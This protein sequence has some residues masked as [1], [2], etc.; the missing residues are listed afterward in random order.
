M[1]ILPNSKAKGSQTVDEGKEA[2]TE[3]HILGDT[4]DSAKPTQLGHSHSVSKSQR[5]RACA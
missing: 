5:G 3:G 2:G 4:V 1:I